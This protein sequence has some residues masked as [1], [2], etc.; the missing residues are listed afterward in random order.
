MSIAAMPCEDFTQKAFDLRP[1][2]REKAG[3]TIRTITADLSRERPALVAAHASNWWLG[4]AISA[5]R[6]RVW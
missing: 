3:M 6:W 4:A 2:T 1:L 5:G